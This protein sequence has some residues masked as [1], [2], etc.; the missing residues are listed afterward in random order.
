M[1]MENKI[2][3]QNS[4]VVFYNH[5]HFSPLA[6]GLFNGE[7]PNGNFALNAFLCVFSNSSLIDRTET[8]DQGF[9]TKILNPIPDFSEKMNNIPGFDEICDLRADEIIKQ[10]RAEKRPIHVFW[11]G[12]ID[13]TAALVALLRNMDASEREELL[14][15]FFNQES[16]NEYERF[17]HDI[18]KSGL[19]SELIDDS[20]KFLLG[21]P[22]LVTGE[23]GDQLFGSVI[24]SEL[25]NLQGDRSHIEIFRQP[26]KTVLPKLIQRRLMTQDMS[27][28]NKLMDF[29][30][31]LVLHCPWK[32]TSTFD[33]LW[34][35]NFTLKWQHVD[36]RFAVGFHLESPDLKQSYELCTHFF[37]TELFQKWSVANP[38]MKIKDTWETYK[39]P[40]KEYIYAFTKDKEYFDSKNKVP[41]ISLRK[42]KQSRHCFMLDDF[43]MIKAQ[44]TMDIAGFRQKFGSN[45]DWLFH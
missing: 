3:N 8:L 37:K 11:S 5:Y 33:C 29:I 24:M 2:S 35:L 15:V 43:K 21:N 36:Q 1:S 41:S 38:D 32:I 9:K 6:F 14:T 40:S 42:I 39:F 17:Y 19:K 23:L 12:G 27:L 34:W 7:P 4:G 18:I 20:Y 31:P 45:Y 16:I 25:L 44:D 13:S 10:A 28:V 22:I 30:E 26:Y